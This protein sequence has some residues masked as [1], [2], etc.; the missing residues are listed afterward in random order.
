MTPNWLMVMRVHYIT[1]N[2]VFLAFSLVSSQRHCEQ[3]YNPHT[4]THAHTK[5][6]IVTHSNTSSYI[7]AHGNTSSHIEAV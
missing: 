3:N 7:A 4:E 1:I 5:K 6:H 2:Q